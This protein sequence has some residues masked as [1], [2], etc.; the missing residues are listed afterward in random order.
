[1]NL[2]NENE[3][4]AVGQKFFPVTV[5][6]ITELTS[7]VVELFLT[8]LDG[9]KALPQ[10][11]SHID[12]I[13]R[14]RVGGVKANSYSLINGPGEDDHFIIAVLKESEHESGSI[15]L[16]NNVGQGDVLFAQKKHNKFPLM[17]N[18]HKHILVAGGIGITPILSMAKFLLQRDQLFE[19]HYSAK[20]ASEMPYKEEILKLTEGQAKLYFTREQTSVKINFRD[21][22]KE[23]HKNNHLYVCGPESMISDAIEISKKMGWASENIHF[24]KF[25]ASGQKADRYTFD[26]KLSNSNKLLKVAANK[27]LLDTLIENN[28]KI[29]FSCKEGLCGSCKVKVLQGDV[30]HRDSILT[31]DEKS[32]GFM[33]SCVSRSLGKLIVIEK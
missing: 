30:C 24:E 27:S 19:I 7:N 12:L 31:D 20:H 32:Q 5:K 23:P 8:P 28:V 9:S 1:M 13:V 17:R 15:F 33:C 18:A 6:K 29:G 10:A 4:L 2:P 25:K 3:A 11:G 22:L 14:D 26:V 16:H 21:I